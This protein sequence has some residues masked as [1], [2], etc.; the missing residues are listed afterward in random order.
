[1]KGK[2]TFTSATIDE[3][4]GLI[5]LRNMT[6]SSGQKTI[7]QKMR[8]I[9]FYG[10]DDWGI[11]DLQVADLNSLIFSGR[12]KVVEGDFKKLLTRSVSPIEKVSKREKEKL[13]LDSII[14][15]NF[16]LEQLENNLFNPQYDSYLALRDKGGVYILCL[17]EN[18]TLPECYSIP[19][20]KCFEGRNVL[21]I[22][23]AS[24]SLRTRDYKQHFMGN[25]AGRSTLRKSLGVMFGFK[26][27]PR[28]KDP[29]SI[30]TKFNDED[31]RQLSAW[32]KANLVMYTLPTPHYE[33]IEM[34]LINHFNPPLNLKSN[35]NSINK[36]FR[37]FLSALRIDK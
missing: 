32:M 15:L 20:Y 21:Y 24:I 31:E 34:L 14:D 2:D 36:D 10:K 9:G 29:N 5:E 18:C 25:N 28:D 7:R 17:K 1:M 30:K 13:L 16:I 19:I 35:N 4:I 23:I 11:V 12:I 6:Q 8:D 33:K 22:G 27:I 3:L 37:K 26:K